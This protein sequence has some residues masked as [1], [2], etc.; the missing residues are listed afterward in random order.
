MTKKTTPALTPPQLE[1]LRVLLGT[2][3]PMTQREI[4]DWLGYASTNAVNEHVKRIESAR[5]GL[6]TRIGRKHTS[7]WGLG[8]E[9]CPCGLLP[10]PRG[11]DVWV[12]WTDE[13]AIRTQ[14]MGVLDD[15]IWRD[16]L[17]GRAYEIPP[18]HWRHLP[19]PPS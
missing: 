11:H 10:P 6:L 12:C 18:S 8:I 4:A 19:A 16:P 3:R 9:W 1:V 17:N 14:G 2:R 15:G 7:P 5:P 13:A